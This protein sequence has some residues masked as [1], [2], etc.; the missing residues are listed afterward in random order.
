MAN[1]TLVIRVA[2]NLAELKKNLKEGKDQ[3][4][5][6]AAGMN[7]LANSFQGEKL[8]QAAHNTTAAIQK[9]GVATLNTSEGARSLTLLDK[10]MDKLMRTGQQV[11][12]EMMKTAAELRRMGRA[13]EEADRAVG[14]ISKNYQQFDG[15]LSAFGINLGPQAK[16]LEDIASAADNGG[17]KITGF[18][19]AGLVMASAMAG[20]K[21]GRAVADFFNLDQAI[22]NATAKLFGWGDVAAEV[23]GAKQDTLMKA[24]ANGATGII[25][26]AQAIEFNRK[27]LEKNTE[28][29][30]D[31]EGRLRA[32]K[33]FVQQLTESERAQIKAAVELGATQEQLKHKFGISAEA[34]KVFK[35]FIEDTTA[36]EKALGDLQKK[37]NAEKLA[38]EQRV[39]EAAE[40]NA[41]R[42]AD[43]AAESAAIEASMSGTKRDRRLADIETEFQREIAKLNKLDANYRTYYD[44]LDRQRA[45]QIAKESADFGRIGEMSRSALQQRADFEKATMDAMLGRSGEFSAAQIQQQRETWR[46]AQDAVR[47]FGLEASA[48]LESVSQKAKEEAQRVAAF[49]GAATMNG[50]GKEFSG[51]I[52]PLTKTQLKEMGTK[53]GQ[54]FSI[55]TL[56]EKL[57]S[58]EDRE[59]TIKPSNN[60]EFFALQR[61]QMLLA[62]LR[63]FF[64]GIGRP[65]T[66]E[67]L[68]GGTP[69]WRGGPALV[70]ERGPE[71]VNLPRGAEVIPNHQIGGGPNISV[72]LVFRGPVIGS[73]AEFQDIVSSAL[74]KVYRDTGLP[75]PAA[76]LG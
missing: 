33:S 65:E 9:V 57:K 24:Y 69:N 18:A 4:E 36:Q 14:R 66:M 52:A 67:G 26:Y 28:Q 76:G 15:I 32:A 7:K 11:P 53:P 64:Q 13:T 29:Y 61:E 5:V 6:V 17:A 27:A 12:P 55:E 72:S 16:G 54:A 51:G 47:N 2:A 3:I 19:K 60:K 23:A 71:I 75:L 35:E 21:I 56:R 22:G 59:G 62:Q 46:A 70:G 42:F 38:D 10:A 58:L 73:T 1:P 50:G 48:I 41:K 49:M 37:I 44:A 34:V 40:Q 45:L 68:A 63:M 25:T 74:L 39:R 8:I 20:W 43:L 31:F 30:G